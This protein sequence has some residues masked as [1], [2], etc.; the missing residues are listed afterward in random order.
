ML[1]SVGGAIDAPEKHQ[2]AIDNLLKMLVLGGMPLDIANDILQSD[3]TTIAKALRVP[4][5]YQDKMTSLT[6]SAQIPLSIYCVHTV[7]RE[8]QKIPMFSNKATALQ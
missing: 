3:D 1:F 8:L 6:Q 5:V 2:Q 7:D 4:K